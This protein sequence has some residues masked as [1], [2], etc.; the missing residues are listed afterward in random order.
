MKTFYY[1][2][3]GEEYQIGFYYDRYV[4]NGNLYI[5]MLNT[6]NPDDPYFADLT[7]NTI[8]LEPFM[9]AIDVQY[10]NN[11]CQWLETIGAGKMCHRNV[12]INFGS[13][14]L[15]KFDPQFLKEVNPEGFEVVR[16]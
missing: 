8:E 16:M 6:G 3:L 14:P 4:K 13:Y 5:G 9:A 11:L 2:F 15:F 12:H 7:I 10:D 1:T